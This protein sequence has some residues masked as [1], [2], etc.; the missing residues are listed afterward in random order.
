MPCLKPTKE[1]RIKAQAGSTIQ[2]GGI[3]SVATVTNTGTILMNNS[4]LFL[5][6]VANVAQTVNSITGSENSLLL[7]DAFGAIALNG[8]IQ[9]GSVFNLAEVSEAS[10]GSGTIAFDGSGTLALDTFRTINSQGSVSATIEGFGTNDAFDLTQINAP[11]L[12]VT[13]TPGTLGIW[14]GLGLVGT[15]D[16]AGSYTASEFQFKPDGNG[17]TNIVLK[18][19]PSNPKADILLQN[20][21]GP[22]ALWQMNGTTITGGDLI[23]QNP[24]PTWFAMGTGAF[25][26]GDTSDVVWQNQNGQVALWQVQG[27]SLLGGG[28]VA[29]NPG[30]TWHIKGTGDFFG[31]GN[32]DILWQ[33]D[34]GSVALWDMSGTNIVGGG[35]A[36]SDPGPTH[37]GHRRLLRRR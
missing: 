22:L 2:I 28:L 12:F 18:A 4:T 14:D 30:P 37:R 19:P 21:S 9:V 26:T 11:S 32:T 23:G 17:G 6:E 10:I 27:T 36:A 24:G 7:G 25:F 8:T 35:L 34:N 15:L 16:L 31:D 20:T 29:N 1:A 13:Y 5:N 33:N 3:G